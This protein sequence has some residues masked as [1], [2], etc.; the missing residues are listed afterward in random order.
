LTSVHAEETL[1]LAS[2][3]RAAAE[4]EEEELLPPLPMLS[5]SAAVTEAAR[6]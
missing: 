1:A 2:S 6:A 4:E 3:R 5:E